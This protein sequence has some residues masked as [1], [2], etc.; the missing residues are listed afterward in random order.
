MTLR[1]AIIVALMLAA[2]PLAGK[3]LCVVVEDRANLNFQAR[4]RFQE[5]LATLVAA[6]G[7]E[8]VLVRFRQVP[9][10]RHATALGLAYADRGRI[11]PIIEVY[12]RPVERL[13]NKEFHAAALG[14]ALARVAAHEIL[15]YRLQRFTHDQAGLFK[16]SLGQADL[17]NT[18]R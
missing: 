17:T 11:L 15:H 18:A 6:G 4:E 8:C 1:G 5:E 10:G 16:E 9:S 13:L 12:V 2:K 3:D 7:E 14:R